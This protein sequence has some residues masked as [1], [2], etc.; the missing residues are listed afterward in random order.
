MFY[1]PV[2]AGQVDIGASYL[3]AWDSN[4]CS[5]IYAV[6]DN[7]DYIQCALTKSSKKYD[8]LSLSEVDIIKQSEKIA[9]TEH[10]KAMIENRVVMLNNVQRIISAA[11]EECKK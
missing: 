1:A 6:T 8:G 4:D 7:N 9:T 10:E 3:I 11:E 5:N 2:D